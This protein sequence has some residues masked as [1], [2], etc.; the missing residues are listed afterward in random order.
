MLKAR[1]IHVGQWVLIFVEDAGA[2]F[3]A[4]ARAMIC[5]AFPKATASLEQL[6][7]SERIPGG[8]LSADY[9]STF[10]ADADL[11]RRKINRSPHLNP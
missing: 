9:L 10:V 5:R 6:G 8:V 2:K 3:A 1:R 7:G 4:A 11:S